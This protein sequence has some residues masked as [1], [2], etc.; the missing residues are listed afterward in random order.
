M[1]THD[2]AT[3]YPAARALRTKQASE[4]A[5]AFDDMYGNQSVSS[6]R[7]DNGGE[8]QGEFAAKLK[9]RKIRHERSLPRRPQTNSR[10]ERFHRTVAEG[11]ACLFVASGVPYAFWTFCLMAFLFVYARSPGAGGVESPYQL[12]FN[13]S[14]DLSKLRPFGSACY[15]LSEEHETGASRGR[16]GVVLGYSRLQSYYVLD[17]EHYVETKGEAR[18]V[19]TRDVRFPPQLRWPFHELGM[20]NPDAAHWAQRFFEPEV[21]QQT[22]VAG[23]DGRCVLCGLW[24]TDA[25]VHCRGCSLGGGRRRH[26]DGPGC[27]RA[28]CGGH[29]F[30]DVQHNSPLPGSH[31]TSM[32]YSPSPPHSRDGCVVDSSMDSSSCRFSPSD[33]IHDD[34]DMGPPP[35][36]EGDGR[37]PTDT[38]LLRPRWR[39]DLFAD[40]QA[41]P[42]HNYGPHFDHGMDSGLVPP[43][44]DLAPS[45]PMSDRLADDLA[46]SS[47]R[48]RSHRGS[49]PSD[50]DSERAS[51]SP[52]GV[53]NPVSS[54]CRS[55]VASHPSDADSERSRSNQASTEL[56]PNGTH[57]SDAD[58]ER[59][60]Q[61]NPDRDNAA[62]SSTVTFESD[63]SGLSTV[64]RGGTVLTTPAALRLEQELDK[65]T[66]EL[67]K[68]F[69][70]VTKIV[71]RRE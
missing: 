6:V 71:K 20:D 48:S 13:R 10:A 27:L 61:P 46:S 17:F 18:I 37:R 7:T 62:V 16:L 66:T 52:A 38:S 30:L 36:D 5:A 40:T 29:S 59:S 26:V 50:A 28:R 43:R 49:H 41:P 19:H 42:G 21:L 32:D 53:Q 2:D 23:D 15:Y 3:G 4:A 25:E 57:S 51:Q 9:E 55:H 12:R 70:C 54:S 31:E 60:Q 64:V 35:D 58:S 11:M 65:L 1:I 44:P 33:D 14:Y 68:M 45:T 8:F 34:D 69:A 67:G 63:R 56:R 24:A 39:V 47:G 22:P